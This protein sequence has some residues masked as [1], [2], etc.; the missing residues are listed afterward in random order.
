MV[1]TN[2]AET[3]VLKINHWKQA[4]ITIELFN[5]AA[6]DF[7]QKKSARFKSTRNKRD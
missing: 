4:L 5:I 1:P 6:N 7:G 2:N 3:D